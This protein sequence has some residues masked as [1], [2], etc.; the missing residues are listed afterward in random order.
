MQL[1]TTTALATAVL[2]AVIGFGLAFYIERKLSSGM[3]KKSQK[4]LTSI[5]MISFGYGL[6]ATLNEVIGFPLQGL[7]I[8][9]DKLAVFVVANMLFL[10]IIFL[11]IAKLIGLKNK[12]LVVDVQQRNNLNM[13]ALTGYFSKPQ[14]YLLFAIPAVLVV[15]YFL[16]LKPNSNQSEVD[17]CVNSSMA[18]W[19]VKQERIKKEWSE[20][21]AWKNDGKW[22][23]DQIISKNE[24]GG[25]DFSLE[26]FG[27]EEK[28]EKR[29]RIEIESEW[30]VY[31]LKINSGK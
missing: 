8:R 13:Q 21:N 29:S 25:R 22:K 30:R 28:V 26:L 6:M 5:A 11:A 18:A 7:S 14:N 27:P 24:G 4:I 9:Y 10:P 20:W 12:I 31:C 1:N 3:Q 2:S 17:K 19:D 23:N 15:A 16:D